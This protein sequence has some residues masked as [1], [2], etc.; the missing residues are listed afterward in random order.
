MILPVCPVSGDRASTSIRYRPLGTAVPRS[1]RPLHNITLRPASFSSLLTRCFITTPEILRMRAC[2]EAAELN[3][4]DIAQLPPGAAVAATWLTT[5]VPLSTGRTLI[6][7][8]RSPPS[9]LLYEYA[10]LVRIQIF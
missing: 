10:L 9:L 8:R 1:E 3:V 2:T 4:Y 6:L 5:G 7:S